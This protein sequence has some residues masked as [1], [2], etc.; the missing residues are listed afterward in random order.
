M[1]VALWTS[2]W[3]K[4]IGTP[5]T[6][7]SM[8]DSQSHMKHQHIPLKFE[9]ILSYGYPQT[10]VCPSMY[11]CIAMRGALRSSYQTKSNH[12]REFDTTQ[13]FKTLCLWV[14]SLFFFKEWVISLIWW[15]T[16][17]FLLNVRLL[18]T[19]K[20]P[21]KIKWIK[22]IQLYFYKCIICYGIN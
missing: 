5:T 4:F 7:H 17:T 21:T 15:S 11:T 6:F 22:I 14:I 1:R 16:F 18:L 8:Q 12:T 19:L 10:K 9:F 20:T 13:N 2:H 3:V